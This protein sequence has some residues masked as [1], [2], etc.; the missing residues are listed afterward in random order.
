MKG[1]IFEKVAYNSLL[2]LVVLQCFPNI[3]WISRKAGCLQ[4]TPS[5]CFKM[6]VHCCDYSTFALNSDEENFGLCVIDNSQS[7]TRDL[8][9]ILMR[10]GIRAGATQEL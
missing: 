10:M 6:C 1:L 5:K 7:S 2:V 4:F 8:E 9:E 3:S